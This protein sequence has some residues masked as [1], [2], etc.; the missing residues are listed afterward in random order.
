MEEAIIAHASSTWWQVT[1][2]Q[3]TGLSVG[4]QPVV[5]GLTPNFPAISLIPPI[6]S[7]F[8]ST[9]HG[10]LRFAFPRVILET[11]ADGKGG[12][13]P[14]FSHFV[15]FSHSPYWLE[16]CTLECL[17]CFQLPSLYL[18]LIFALT[19]LASPCHTMAYIQGTGWWLRMVTIRLCL[20]YSNLKQANE[21]A[22]QTALWH[23]DVKANSTHTCSVPQFAAKSSCLFLHQ[24]APVWVEYTHNNEVLIQKGECDLRQ[25]G[26]DEA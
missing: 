17:S 21:S 7:F 6:T 24:W 23:H 20:N 16:N 3:L 11:E 5:A 13:K 10:T 14:S 19:K 12:T 22:G 15:K 18:A 8:S 9:C 25:V 4:Y 2:P 1:N 26:L